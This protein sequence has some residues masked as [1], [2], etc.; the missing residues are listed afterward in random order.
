MSGA[1]AVF[2]G[3]TACFDCSVDEAQDIRQP[4]TVVAGFVASLEKWEKW[5][6]GW[7]L[8]LKEF[9]APYFHMKELF[10]TKNG[11]FAD[12]KW[13]NEAYRNKFVD[14]LSEVTSEC[15]AATI[16]GRMEH[17]LFNS[18]NQVCE[19]DG[20]FNPFSA[21]GRDCAVRAKYLI[22]GK[23]KS[24]LPIA[25]IFE[26][27]DKGAEMLD[28]LMLQSELPSPLFKRPRPGA[29]KSLEQEDPH[30]PQLQ[31]ADLLAWYLRRAAQG[32]LNTGSFSISIKQ[33][34][35]IPDVSWKDC[36]KEEMAALLHSLSVKR[37]LST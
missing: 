3:Y 20:V 13:K 19:I 10:S 8:V 11:V 4:A 2:Q 1:I 34:R 17:H 14:A 24:N 15:M 29:S 31:A 28:R 7:K 23:Y 25:Y 9:N 16:G 37:R 6:V 36:T 30:L 21:C 27:G 12:T 26:R 33:L 32:R 35:N 18:A 22:R 5:E